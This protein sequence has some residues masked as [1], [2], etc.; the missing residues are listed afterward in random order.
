M[1]GAGRL[2]DTLG[3]DLERTEYVLETPTRSPFTEA[4]YAAFVWDMAMDADE[5]SGLLG[6]VAAVIT[7]EPDTRDEVLGVARM[8]FRDRLGLEGGPWTD[9]TFRCDVSAPTR[10]RCGNRAWS[11]RRAEFSRRP[12]RRPGCPAAAPGRSR[13]TPRGT[14]RRPP[15]TRWPGSA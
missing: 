1:A 2:R 15:G 5:L 8:L 7:M 11:L 9:V 4:E 3:D 12:P 13:P 6:T 14:T 10:Q